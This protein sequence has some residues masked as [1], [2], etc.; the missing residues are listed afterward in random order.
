M[1]DIYAKGDFDMAGF[2]VGVVE[3]A[4]M[5]DG[6]KVRPGDA[7]LGLASSG[8]HANGYSLIRKILEVSGAA[9]DADLDGR[10]L[11]HV[12]AGVLLNRNLPFIAVLKPELFA[13]L[14]S[15]P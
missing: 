7:L 14:L 11:G 15:N 1:P 8:P 2:C 13:H 6:A 9:L 5:I 3:K 10:P 12:Q 4:R